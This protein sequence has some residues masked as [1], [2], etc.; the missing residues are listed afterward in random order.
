M[1]HATQVKLARRLLAYMD[2][3]TTATA[4]DVF[5]NP[6]RAYTSPARLAREREILF[7]RHPLL[8]GL[9]CEV[10]R[11]G[12]FLCHDDAGAPI[13]LLRADS[14]QLGA[15]LNV[16]RHRGARVA[17]G[18]GTLKPAFTCPY[19]AWSYDREGGLVSIPHREA[20]DGVDRER[21][22]LTRLP[23]QEKYGLIWARPRP[24]DD[25]DIDAHLGGLGPELGSYG[26]ETYHHYETRVLQRQ[27]NWKLVIDTFL[28]TYHLPVLHRGTVSPLIHG[29]LA[30]FDP[31]GLNLRMVA[32]R[33]TLEELRDQPEDE[34]DLISHAAIIYVLFPNTVF[35]IQGDHVE[36]WRAYPV[37]DRPDAC[38]IHLSLYTPEP[39][40]TE[41]A[42]RHWNANLKL[43]LDTVDAE[44]FPLCESIQRGF[45]SGAQDYVTYGRNEP[46]LAH[47]HRSLRQALLLGGRTPLEGPA[48]PRA[49]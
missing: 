9:S 8:L 27:L 29:N 44:D 19:H 38:T 39:A 4:A 32:A 13:L 20:F 47:Y 15:L 40:R 5:R 22:G 30:T 26:L 33:R 7:A 49:R 21:Q 11:P 25:F 35:I 6:V 3:G 48:P 1:E 45:Y 36:I 10:G 12:D 28:E 23:V 37:P 17:E 24:G 41:S 2:A 18:R 34:W 14:G 16:C 43:A 46:S 31:F 42:V